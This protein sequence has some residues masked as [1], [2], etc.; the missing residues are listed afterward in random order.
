MCGPEA[1]A[2][3]CKRVDSRSA[4]GRI[5]SRDHSLMVLPR[6]RIRHRYESLRHLGYDGDQAEQWPV[7]EFLDALPR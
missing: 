3:A 5:V 2:P 7:L 6:G 1:K 4:K